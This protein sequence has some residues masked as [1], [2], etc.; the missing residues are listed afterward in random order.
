MFKKKKKKNP[1]SPFS[2]AALLYMFA[3][4]PASTTKLPHASSMCRA[5]AVIVIL[6]RYIIIQLH[7]VLWKKI[8]LLVILY[9]MR[10][11]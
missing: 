11:K 10:F 8:H 3:I 4:L 6:C 5:T 2:R 9:I 7:G 1:S